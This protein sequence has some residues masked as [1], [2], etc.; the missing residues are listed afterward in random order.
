MGKVF[1]IKKLRVFLLICVFLLISSS[2][3]GAA[4][5]SIEGNP[6]EIRAENEGTMGAFRWEEGSLKNQYYNGDCWGSVLLINGNSGSPRKFISEEI[7]DWMPGSSGRESFTSVSHEKIG[8]WTMRTVYSAGDSGIEITQ[9]IAYTNGNSYYRKSWEIKNNSDDQTYTDLRFLHGGDAYFGGYDKSLGHWDPSLRMVYLTNPDMGI[10]GIMGFYGAASSP[11]NHFFEGFYD[12]LYENMFLGQLPDTVR[13]DYHDSGYA[14]Q[15]N[16]ASLAP[17]ETWNIV[18]YE[19]WT[20]AGFVQVFGP[21]D[22]EGAPGETISYLFTISNEQAEETVFNF[23]AVSSSGWAT[24]LPV[25]SLSIPAGQTAAVAVELTIAQNAEVG[26]EDILTL[27]ATAADDESVSNSDSV[28]TEVIPV[29]RGSLIVTIEPAGAV[30]AGAQWRR[31]GSTI[32]LNSGST[33]TNI[34]AGSYTVEFKEV[35]GFVKPASI[36]VTILPDQIVNAA[37]AYSEAVPET[38][39]PDSKKEPEAGAPKLPSTGGGGLLSVVPGVITVIAG[40]FLLRK[41]RRRAK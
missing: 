34:P 38:D 3:A 21:S 36:A 40:A 1:R 18:S 33:E 16:R 41:K 2:I 17:G 23:T 32:W 14:L 25:S 24:A 6:L 4:L 20:E 37:A 12:D 27:T 11:A 9:I 19:K 29:K 8:D 30:A 10:S 5:L 28:T 39:P 15:W 22:E 35:T 31:T 7:Y 26:A 13:N